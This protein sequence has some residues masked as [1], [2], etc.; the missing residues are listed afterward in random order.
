[1]AI[2]V[3][4]LCVY[5]V[6][7]LLF[8][9]FIQPITILSAIPLSIGGAFFGLLVFDS[10]LGLPAMIGL[11]MLMGIVTTNSILLV[12]FAIAGIRERG[13]ALHDALIDDCHKRAR[14][15]VMTSSEE[16]REGKGSASTCRSR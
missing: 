15:I 5:C 6:L 11:V 1:M 13:L 10:E 4:I 8:K 16:G 2:V 14:P 7:V 12:D 3:G 9:D